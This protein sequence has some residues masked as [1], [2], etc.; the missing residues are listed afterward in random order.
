M[1][2]VL[3][4]F[5]VLTRSVDRGLQ[6]HIAFASPSRATRLTCTDSLSLSSLVISALGSS[7][8]LDLRASADYDDGVL[9]NRAGIFSAA[10]TAVAT[11][12]EEQTITTFAA[13][14]ALSLSAW[15]RSALALTARA[16][17]ILVL[18]HGWRGPTSFTA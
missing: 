1:L 5:A 8:E 13:A 17:P 15:P 6:A 11:A 9:E 3:A 2:G 12:C 4:D 18:P 16:L 14:I 7:G 10:C